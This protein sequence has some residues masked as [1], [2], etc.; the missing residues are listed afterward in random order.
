[1]EVLTQFSHIIYARD[2]ID[3]VVA[4]HVWWR[5]KLSIKIFLINHSDDR[6]FRY[7]QPRMM[8]FAISGAVLAQS[9]DLFLIGVCL[10]SIMVIVLRNSVMLIFK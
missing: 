4:F 5:G 6:F 7:N 2:A 8:R 10:N 1:V 9:I 3:H